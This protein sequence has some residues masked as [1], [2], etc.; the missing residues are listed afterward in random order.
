[1]QPTVGRK[2][3][4]KT[5]RNVLYDHTRKQD[6]VTNNPVSKYMYN[7]FPKFKFLDSVVVKVNDME[8]EREK[9]K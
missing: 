4:S 8:Y 6:R 9:D 3:R 5:V 1:V 7:N 2:E